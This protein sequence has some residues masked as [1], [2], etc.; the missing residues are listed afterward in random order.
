MDKN[1]VYCLLSEAIDGTIKMFQSKPYFFLNECDIHGFLYSKLL[2][3]FEKEDMDSKTS[4]IHCEVSLDNNKSK[5]DLCIWDTT[6]FK[7]NLKAKRK[8]NIFQFRSKFVSVEIKYCL[9]ESKNKVLKKIWNPK[10]KD[11]TQKGDYYKL[12]YYKDFS[13]YCIIFDTG[14][15]LNVQDIIQIQK[16]NN[17]FKSDIK[18]VYVTT[19]KVICVQNSKECELF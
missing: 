12:Y 9:G 7:I 8:E 17:D 1:K 5:P 2:S 6:K 11:M 10:A 19:E 15:K 3:K 4:S 14:A 16:E 18:I 13:S